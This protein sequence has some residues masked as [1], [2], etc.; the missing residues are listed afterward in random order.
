MTTKQNEPVLVVVQLTGGNDSMN[1]VLP[2]DDPLYY[3]YRPNMGIPQDQALPI[4]DRLAFH[5]AMQPLKDLYDQ[6]K[7]AVLNGIGYPHPNRSHFRSMDIW[8]TA[9]PD[10]VG[11]EGWL[12]RVIRD[13]DPRGENVLTGINFGRGLPRSMLAP[14]V[15]VTSVA[16]LESYGVLNGISDDAERL[17]ALDMFA[18]MYSPTLGRGP[19]MDYLERIGTDALKGADILRTA[20][21]KYQSTVEYADTRVARDLQS[22]AT[23]L[24]ADLGARIFY[25]QHSGYDTHINMLQNHATLWANVSR[26]I[27]DFYLDLREH[28]ASNNVLIFLFS[29]FGR[30]ARENGAGTDH[31]SGG[32]AMLIG[33]PVKGGIYGEQPSLKFGDL[34]E[35]DL[36]FNLDFRGVYGTI[37]EKWLG[38]D[39]APIIGVGFEQSDFV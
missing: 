16:S 18:Q 34:L 22:V 9:E 33:D 29:E 3:D 30:R 27:T 25:T 28:N 20:P 15:P 21:A 10:K 38:L 23:V 32:V 5:P 14:G 13:L 2:Y 35:G 24:L 12:A 11:S 8:H 26:A 7:V 36:H 6:G 31:G 39:A 1:T 37:A 17:E 19:V 4:D